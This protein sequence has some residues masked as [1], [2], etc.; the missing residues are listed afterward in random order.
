MGFAIIPSDP[1]TSAA[2]AMSDVGNFDASGTTS[3]DTMLM[4]LLEDYQL[5]AIGRIGDTGGPNN[6]NTWVDGDD[7]DPHLQ[8]VYGPWVV[9][10]KKESMLTTKWGQ[11]AFNASSPEGW[12][13]YIE[14]R[15]VAGCVTIATAQLLSYFRFPNSADGFT[16]NWNDMLNDSYGMP[17]ESTKRF[18]A[19]VYNHLPGKTPGYTSTGIPDRSV[20]DCLSDLGCRDDGQEYDYDYTRIINSIDGGSP[21]LMDGYSKVIYVLGIP[22]NDQSTGHMWVVDG[23]MNKMQE[24]AI[25]PENYVTNGALQIKPISTHY[26][27]SNYLHCNWGWG[28]VADGYYQAGVFNTINGPVELGETD[29]NIGKG[30]SHYSYDMDI[31]VNIK[32]R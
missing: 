30:K 16:Y 31:R 22:F 27:Y 18:I 12:N 32:P 11:S 8:S 28:G 6:P 5:M 21:V 13:D 4:T 7:G 23:Y 20:V 14:H 24:I 10:Y 19:C 1:R 2:I 26:L 25:Y 9:T 29:L 15:Y 3:G 17:C